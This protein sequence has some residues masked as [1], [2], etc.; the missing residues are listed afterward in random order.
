VEDAIEQ[1][2]AT[3]EHLSHCHKQH[4]RIC[5]IVAKRVP[6]AGPKLQ[7]LKLQ[8]IRKHHALLIVDTDK[9]IIN[10][11]QAPYQRS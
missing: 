7:S 2:I 8:M 10:I 5:H 4:V 3:M 1:L 11:D 9:A 6:R